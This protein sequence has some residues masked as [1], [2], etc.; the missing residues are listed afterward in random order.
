MEA[1]TKQKIGIKICKPNTG[2]VRSDT[3]YFLSTNSDSQNNNLCTYLKVIVLE[4]G[5]LGRVVLRIKWVEGHLLRS[6]PN[7]FVK[8]G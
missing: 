1:D 5:A 3:A 8:H 2:Q 6:V 4:A 7:L